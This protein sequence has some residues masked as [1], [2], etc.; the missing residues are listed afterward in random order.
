MH[1]TNQDEHLMKQDKQEWDQERVKE[2]KFVVCFRPLLK[3]RDTFSSFLEIHYT[4][5]FNR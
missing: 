5:S 4:A 3:E 1:N 2:T